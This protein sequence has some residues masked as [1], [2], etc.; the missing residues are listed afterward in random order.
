MKFLRILI[1]VVFSFIP[2]LL[3]VA[4]V[5]RMFAPGT[6]QTAFIF[7]KLQ[8]VQPLLDA[9]VGVLIYPVTFIWE[10]LVGI[11]PALRNPWFP[12]AASDKV[13]GVLVALVLKIPRIMDVPI[14]PALR[15]ANL[16]LLF[17]GIMDWRLL[18][19][20]PLWGTVESLC[21]QI[22][23]KIEAGQYRNYI[24]QRDAEMLR[25][26]KGVGSEQAPAMSRVTEKE[27]LFRGMVQGLKGEI[28]NLQGSMS[29][30]P[31]TRLFSRNHFNQ[32]LGKEMAKARAER[33]HLGLLMIDIDDFKM[34]NEKYGQA[35]GDTALAQVAQ[36][37]SQMTPTQGSTIACRYGGEEIAVIVTDTSAR[38]VE[39]LG[40][41]ICQE[42]SKIR[43]VE[44][45]KAK[46]TVSIGAYTVCFV[47]TN[48]SFELTESSFVAKADSQ[49]YIA[50]RSGKN[51]V[52]ATV[53]P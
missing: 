35:V 32:R 34:L 44:A 12:I 16:N 41:A 43:L 6:E 52:V 20:L 40:E 5:I 14:G 25:S 36:V 1:R 4:F 45:P 7:Q 30:D 46:I 28:S 17:P 21:M 3:L 38:A 50:K 33:K 11:M 29:L 13:M 39:Q 49:M 15:D 18:V 27:V 19:V 10:L 23:S 51:R 37:A 26:F 47:P 9:V 8:L 53:L 42:V 24:Q 31:L 2:M 22:I 48:G